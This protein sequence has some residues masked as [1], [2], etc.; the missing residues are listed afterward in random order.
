MLGTEERHAE[1]FASKPGNG[2]RPYGAV[3]CA[4][5]DSLRRRDAV[6]P[7]AKRALTADNAKKLNGQTPV[8]LLAQAAKQPGPA[9]SAASLITIKTAAWSL[10]PRGEGNFTATCD[11]GQKVI[12]GGWA[13]PGD[14]SSGFQSLPTAD[15]TGWTINI[16]TTSSAPSTQSGSVYAICLK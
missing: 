1:V 14:W 10:A 11:P 8:A 15:G 13:D 7:L 9:S 12:A 5:G 4:F 2:R 3:R 6:V 16:F